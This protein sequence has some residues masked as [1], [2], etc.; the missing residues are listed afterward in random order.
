LGGHRLRQYYEKSLAEG[1][2]QQS[3]QLAVEGTSQKKK[4]KKKLG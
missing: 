4:G 2:R 3:S 1:Q